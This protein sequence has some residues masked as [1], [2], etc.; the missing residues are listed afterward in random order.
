MRLKLFESAQPIEKLK[1]NIEKNVLPKFA[2]YGL[3][4]S[5]NPREINKYKYR[6]TGAT[7]GMNNDLYLSTSNLAI[8]EWNEENSDIYN[9]DL[10]AEIVMN[11]QSEELGPISSTDMSSI[12]DNMKD[13]NVDSYKTMSPEQIKDKKL[14]PPNETTSGLPAMTKEEWINTYN[15]LYNELKDLEN[16]MAKAEAE[17]DDETYYK[18]ASGEYKEKR[19]YWGKKFLPNYPFV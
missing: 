11:G 10:F 16:Q 12:D 15:K 7:K 4:F 6:Y 13:I 2:E 3:E 8:D 19:D 5:G 14:I 1:R 9:A 18:I 17:D